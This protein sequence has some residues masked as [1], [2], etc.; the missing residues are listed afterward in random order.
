MKPLSRLACLFCLL[1][2]APGGAHAQ[3]SS[4][5]PTAD[6]H[7]GRNTVVQWQPEAAAP[8]VP[9]GDPV[10]T[11]SFSERMCNCIRH[12]WDDILTDDYSRE[13]DRSVT[14]LALKADCK[15]LCGSPYLF[16][17]IKPVEY[18]DLEAPWPG[19]Q[20]WRALGLDPLP[21]VRYQPMPPISSTLPMSSGLPLR[22]DSQLPMPRKMEEPQPTTVPPGTITIYRP[23]KESMR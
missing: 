3:Q 6:P 18:E 9:P 23:I 8:A 4:P 21:P 19:P 22:D 7:A 14:K 1:L 13:T 20:Q 5:P 10:S 2:A 12:A 15:M 17:R 16:Y 11:P